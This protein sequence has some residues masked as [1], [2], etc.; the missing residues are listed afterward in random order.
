MKLITHLL[1]LARAAL[2]ARVSKRNSIVFKASFTHPKFRLEDIGV[3]Q[4]IFGINMKKRLFL[5]FLSLTSLL[6]LVYG[7]PMPAR[8]SISING[9][10]AKGHGL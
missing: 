8:A 7:L 5:Y 9:I 4:S 2:L 10:Y 3:L 6:T 1:S